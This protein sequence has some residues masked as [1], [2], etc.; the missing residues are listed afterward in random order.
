MPSPITRLCAVHP[1]ALARLPGALSRP[2][3]P[4]PSAPPEAPPGFAPASAPHRLTPRVCSRV[5]TFL[6]PFRARRRCHRLVLSAPSSLAGLCV[7]GSVCRLVLT[8]PSWAR[9]LASATA[10]SA[11]A[12]VS[13]LGHAISFG[14][15]KGPRLGKITPD[16]RSYSVCSIPVHR[17]PTGRSAGTGSRAR[18]ARGGGGRGALPRVP[19]PSGR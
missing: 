15:E 13:T 10:R 17:F 11:P 4:R 1:A 12:A 19:S 3:A 9:S 2:P 18:A 5:R 8:V 7:A 6:A 16:T 14:R